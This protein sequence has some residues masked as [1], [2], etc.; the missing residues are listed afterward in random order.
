MVNSPGSFFDPRLE[1]LR[2]WAALSVVV[3]HA[4]GLLRV[5]GMTAYWLVPLRE[6]S[7]TGLILTILGGIFNP[8]VAVALFFVLSGYVLALS[9]DLNRN[10]GWC[11]AYAVRRAFRLLPAMWVSIGV[12]WICLAAIPAP[13]SLEPFSAFFVGVF[14]RPVGAMDAVANAFLVSNRVNPVT[15]T[16]VA[17]VIGSVFVPISVLLSARFGRPV[18]WALLLVS[19]ILAA[20][21]SPSSYAVHYLICFQLG[22]MLA[23]KRVSGFFRHD[24]FSPVVVLRV[25]SG[26]MI[27]AGVL[28]AGTALVYRTFINTG[29]AVVIIAAVIQG[30]SDH[31]LKARPCRFLGKNSYSLYLLHLPVLYGVGRLAVAMGVTGP[32]PGPTLLVV[33]AGLIGAIPAA[34]LGF[35]LVERPAIAVGRKVAG[36]LQHRT[37]ANPLARGV[38]GGRELVISRLK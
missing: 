38:F 11:R 4:M 9:L 6:Q 12:M 1:S 19:A 37:A 20:T 17:E 2:G 14:T 21:T 18:A 25:A 3:A 7:S 10:P 8:G 32:G 27:L 16:M 31:L 36:K 13:D 22:V 30:G 23:T 33:S 26:L 5:D 35:W 24:L 34:G 28:V 15:W 29:I